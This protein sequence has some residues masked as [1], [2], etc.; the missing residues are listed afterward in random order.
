MDLLWLCLRGWSSLVG[1]WVQCL[2]I[3]YG[4]DDGPCVVG[5]EGVEMDST[6]AVSIEDERNG[7]H[8]V[9]YGLVYIPLS[10]IVCVGMGEFIDLGLIVL[11]FLKSYD[12]LMNAIGIEIAWIVGFLYLTLLIRGLRRRAGLL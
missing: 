2:G 3:G 1:R 5:L 8:F 4:S 12:E 10:D 9:E 6:V 7:R 11:L